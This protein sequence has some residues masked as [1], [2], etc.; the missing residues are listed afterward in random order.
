MV[1]EKLPKKWYIIRDEDNYEVL[2]KWNNETYP[3][4]IK[5]SQRSTA[6]FYSDTDYKAQLLD[7]YTQI[8]LG[9]FIIH[10]LDKNTESLI[11]NY[12][13]LIPLFKTLNIK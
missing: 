9:D 6:Y 12:N 4:T 10:V 8:T 13:Y 11:Q 7:G 3:N 1:L 5:A 2:N